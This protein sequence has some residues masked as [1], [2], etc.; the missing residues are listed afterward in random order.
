MDYRIREVLKV[1]DELSKFAKEWPKPVLDAE[2]VSIG[3]ETSRNACAQKEFVFATP[4]MKN[5]LVVF[6]DVKQ[7]N[8]DGEWTT[9]KLRA[10]AKS[11]AVAW[12]DEVV[13]AALRKYNGAPKDKYD[14]NLPIDSK[15]LYD[16][17]CWLQWNTEKF[18]DIKPG[19]AEER[20]KQFK[21]YT[22]P[23]TNMSVEEMRHF[24]ETDEVLQA[25]IVHL[26][27][28]WPVTKAS[29]EVREI[30]DP[31]MNKKTGVSYPYFRNDATLVPGQ[32]ITYGRLCINIVAKAAKKGLRALRILAQMNNVYTGYPRNQRGKG[33]ALEA[34][35]RIV[36]L[37][38]NMLNANEIANLQA[39]EYGVGL[40]NEQVI[41]ERL[42]EVAEFVLKHP[43]YIAMNKDFTGWDRT[44]GAGWITLQNALR[45]L[46]A[47]GELAKEI[48]RIR[49]ACAM[50]AQFIDGPAGKV[51]TI[52]GRTMSGYD[53]TTNQNCCINYLQ[54]DYNNRI[55]DENYAENVT[56]P[57]KNR[58]I[59]VLGDDYL[60][61]TLKGKEGDWVKS[62]A[63]CGFEA[64]ADFKDAFGAMFVQ[65][66]VF[67][68]D[69]GEWVSVYAWPRVLRSMLSKEDQKS[70]GRAGWT[71]S[72]YQQLGKLREFPEALMI[73]SNIAAALDKDH[74]SLNTPISELL[75]MSKQE[76]EERFSGDIKNKSR[77]KARALSTAERLSN[78]P[79]LPGLKEVNGKTEIDEDYFTKL[80]GEIRSVYDPEFLQKLGF[81]NPD[82]AKVH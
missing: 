74:L 34:E 55:V 57:M 69:K 2:A 46:C 3:L 58:N 48:V 68:N 33:R 27:K 36:N 29:W 22:N 32:N 59:L 78:N 24:I 35:S 26:L 37:I 45:Y 8:K 12:I 66:R 28:R 23:K 50:S 41:K 14:H 17:D 75:Q 15:E 61:I 72:F 70:L 5:L 4:L 71:F 44:V 81:R 65:Y 52:F 11:K 13:R 1:F 20:S 16:T 63:R 7:I 54:S 38:V 73:A 43:Q 21:E 56:Y 53:D 77:K 67:R 40:C 42:V 25:C 18:W 79:M 80:Q 76:D 49:H 9:E 19:Q 31:F 39:C 10:G 51:T 47:N 60:G 64:H 82:L 30:S 6:G 62:A